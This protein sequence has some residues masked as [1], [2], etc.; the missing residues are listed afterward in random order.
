MHLGYHYLRWPLKSQELVPAT[1][2]FLKKATNE[3]ELASML[4]W[5]KPD[6]ITFIKEAMAP[7]RTAK[8]F[9]KLLKSVREHHR[10]RA[11]RIKSG[12][13][14]LLIPRKGLWA[15]W[16]RRKDNQEL[17]LPGDL[18]AFEWLS[19]CKRLTLLT[20]VHDAV[21]GM[22][23]SGEPKQIDLDEIT[24]LPNPLAHMVSQA[25]VLQA[26]RLVTNLSCPWNKID[27]AWLCEELCGY[28]IYQPAR[29]F[30]Y[31]YSSVV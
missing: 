27:P 29:G 23:V 11:K 18:E 8:N 28:V 19:R 13:P 30:A 10:L 25:D 17:A 5:D 7:D 14:D 12:H 22:V 2:E 26:K 20:S 6:D 24:A 3:T 1:A 21:I 4:G 16:L 9:L 15:W 31:Y